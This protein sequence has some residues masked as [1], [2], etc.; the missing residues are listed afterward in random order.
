MLILG[1]YMH[2]PMHI[3]IHHT[4]MYTYMTTYTPPRSHMQ[5]CIYTYM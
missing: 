5:M 1:L 2:P 3:H 4:H